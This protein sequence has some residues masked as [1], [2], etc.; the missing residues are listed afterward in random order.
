MQ[1]LT[2]RGQTYIQHKVPAEKHFKE[3]TYRRNVYSYR[4]E[5][6]SIKKPCLT[7]RGIP[8]QN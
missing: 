2:Y 1:A 8:Y 7:Y 3:L 6:A 5:E 4:K